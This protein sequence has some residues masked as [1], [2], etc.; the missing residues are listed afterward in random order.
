MSAKQTE[1]TELL[2]LARGMKYDA[3]FMPDAK[4]ETVNGLTGKLPL[5]NSAEDSGEQLPYRIIEKGKIRVGIISV[6]ARSF[7]VTDKLAKKLKQEEKYNVVVCLS[8]LGY[9][10]KKRLSDITLAEKSTSIDV[11]LGSG[12]QAFMTTPHVTS[13]KLKNE[14]II[15][16]VG[17]G[18][19][20][21]GKL[22][23]HFNEEGQKQKVVFDNLMIG[24]PEPLEERNRMMLCRI[25][26]MCLVSGS[27]M[28]VRPAC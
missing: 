19:I 14:V 1:H 16:H 2:N 15:N 9:D 5:V 22:D 10:K 25:P 12:S 28:M 6:T 26:F 20:V 11:I 3:V 17:Y 7:F 23:I 18:G 8:S 24:T 27:V 21:L 13:N 4:T